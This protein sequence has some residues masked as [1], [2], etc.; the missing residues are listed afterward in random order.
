MVNENYYEYCKGVLGV[1][2]NIAGFKWVYG[3]VA[4]SVSAEQYEICAVRFEIRL[5][6]ENELGRIDQYDE[7]FQSY[8]WNAQNQTVSF[9]RNILGSIPIGY[10]IA[11]K[12][13]YVMAEIGRN[14]YGL[15]KKRV[16]NLHDM[17]FLLSDIANLV[18][19][20]NGYLTLYAS[21][22][23]YSLLNKGVAFFAAPSTG[24]TVTATGLC[25]KAGYSLIG[26]DILIV[27]DRQL[28]SCPWTSSYRGKRPL[29]DSTSALRRMG[30]QDV[31]SIC[32]VCQL[33][34]MIALVDGIGC[35][36]SDK[37]ELLRKIMIL[38]GYLFHY[39]SSP[40][41][42]ILSFFNPEYCRE[43]EEVA[44]KTLECLVAGSECYIVHST[45][46]LQYSAI[47]HEIVTGG[48]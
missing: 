47:V 29:L 11:I 8:Y 48:T 27:K 40:I 30:K 46:A 42:K 4:P 39:Y 5:K 15:V 25:R 10:N 16:M 2:T 33:T 14:Y 9:R 32:D 41:I 36:A 18:L 35:V 37:E 20:K 43:W 17:Y 22:V 19:L 28:F 7:R 12:K 26:E 34:D 13:N 23:H 6:P 38:N 21:G 44:R 45:E 24:K 1:K 31:I 3:S